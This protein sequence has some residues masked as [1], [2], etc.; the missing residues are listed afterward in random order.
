ME[1]RDSWGEVRE[2]RVEGNKWTLVEL[3]GEDGHF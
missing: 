3:Y 2:D 1:H